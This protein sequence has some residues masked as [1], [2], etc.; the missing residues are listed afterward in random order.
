MSQPRP[1]AQTDT[2]DPEAPAP[3]AAHAQRFTVLVGPFNSYPDSFRRL[4]ELGHRVYVLHVSPSLVHFRGNYALYKELGF[5][6]VPDATALARA[7]AAVFPAGTGAR[8]LVLSGAHYYP[9]GEVYAFGDH[10]RLELEALSRV[11]EALCPLGHNLKLARLNCGETFFTGPKSVA[12]FQQHLAATD[13]MVVHTK[14]LAASI[15]HHCPVFRGTPFFLGPLNAPLARAVTPPHPGPTTPRYLYAG[16]WG[17]AG[18][19]KVDK[20]V[21]EITFRRN[22]LYLA[23]KADLATLARDRAEARRR[24][25][26]HAGGLSH[27]Y[28]FF[29]HHGEDPGAILT[30]PAT[31]QALRHA[32]HT[33]FQPRVFRL[34]NVAGKALTYLMLGIPP[35]VP[36]DPAND[37]HG[38]LMRRGMC[39]PVGPDA[40][41]PV[42]SEAELARIRANIAANPGIFCMDRTFAALDRLLDS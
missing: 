10:C 18:A 9:H 32:D 37:F 22:P 16:R 35:I 11:R 13:L 36:A 26:A 21:D 30:E 42:S 20:P 38:E 3:A 34:T 17:S 6:V 41:I 24:Y 1:P 4:L 28:D 8:G 27:F 29:Q 15:V 5:A 14:S 23:C 19:P 33:Y 2:E 7:V 12:V 39:L 40:R 31:R 25:G